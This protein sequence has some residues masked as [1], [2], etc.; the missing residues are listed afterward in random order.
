MDDFTHATEA[1]LSWLRASGITISPKIHLADLRSRNASRGVVALSN[2]APD[3]ELFRIPRSIILTP[4]SLPSLPADADPWTG[5]ILSLIAAHNA[6]PASP[7]APYLAVL[8]PLE[9]FNTLLFWT[10]GELAELQA[11]PVLGRIGAAEAREM[12]AER[13]VPVI[14]AEPA[15][16]GYAASPG[17]D[18]IFATANR[19]ASIIMAYAFD[20]ERD[21]AERQPDEEGYVTEDEDAELPKGMV[22]LADALNADGERNNAR[23]FYEPDAL[24]MKAI[25]PIPAGEECLNDYGELPRAEVLRRY[26]FVSPTYAAWDVAEVEQS[27]IDSVLR[28]GGIDIPFYTFAAERNA[29]INDL[30]ILDDAYEITRLTPDVHGLSIFDHALRHQ[31]LLRVLEPLPNPPPKPSHTAK[32]TYRYPRAWFAVLEQVIEAKLRQYGTTLFEDREILASLE[33]AGEGAGRRGMAVQVRM[34]EKEVLHG[35]LQ[36]LALGRREAAE[37]DIGGEKRRREEGEEGG[38]KVRRER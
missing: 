5:L 29:L 28:A 25:K 18:E 13:V 27:L 17:R 11:S 9:A 24:V 34:A 3:E 36:A 37:V 30:E 2:I 19:F 10:E 23:L 33:R 16:Y 8:P 1:Y 12:I 22:P 14:E 26:G 32:D 35:A 31:I 20:I 38:R 15:R 6:G 7:W 4:S 21:P